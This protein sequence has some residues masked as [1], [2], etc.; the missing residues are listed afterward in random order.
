MNHT[1]MSMIYTYISKAS[2]AVTSMIY[3]ENMNDTVISMICST[4]MIVRGCWATPISSQI[5]CT[6]ITYLVQGCW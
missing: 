2:A 4:R 3:A 1:N 6:S 5:N